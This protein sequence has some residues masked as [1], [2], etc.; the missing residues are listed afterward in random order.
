MQ[1]FSSIKAYVLEKITAL[2]VY[3][4]HRS[5][6]EKDVLETWSGTQDVYWFSSD[7]RVLGQAT[8]FGTII[9]NRKRLDECDREDLMQV[10]E[11][12]VGHKIRNPIAKGIFYGLALIWLPIGTVFLMIAFGYA[13]I[14]PL[15][16]PFEPVRI[17]VVSAIPLIGI[18][19]A[20]WRTEEIIADFHV[21]KF[22]TYD[23]YLGTYQNLRSEDNSSIFT[24]TLFRLVYTKPENIVRLHQFL[25]Q[26]RTSLIAHT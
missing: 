5:R 4:I 1:K 9:L 26:Y 20:A 10:A 22:R 23:E 6:V 19:L 11:H 18:G 8:L 14:V 24:A 3:L 2:W 16:G 12:E 21:L 13:M 7:A 25:T 15:G 17:L